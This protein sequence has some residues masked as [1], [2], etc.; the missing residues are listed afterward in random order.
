MP[1]IC[2]FLG[3]VIF[4]LHDDHAPPHFHAEYGEYKIFVEMFKQAFLSPVLHMVV[5]PNGADFAPEYL[6]GKLIGEAGAH[7]MVAEEQ[8]EYGKTS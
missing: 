5:W 1:E 7:L 2:R 8:A 3:I 4:M 6:R